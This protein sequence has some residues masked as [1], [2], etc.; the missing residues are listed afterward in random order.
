MKTKKIRK[1]IFSLYY[2]QKNMLNPLVKSILKSVHNYGR[3][4]Q[5]RDRRVCSF[6]H[7]A[8]RSLQLRAWPIL[9]TGLRPVQLFLVFYWDILYIRYKFALYFG[10]PARLSEMSF[11]DLLQYFVAA[12]ADVCHTDTHSTNSYC[13]PAVSCS[14]GS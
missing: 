3:Y 6:H 12:H 4:L 8:T 1:K 9:R 13:V 7:V 5:F 14:E 11:P 2:D 10:I